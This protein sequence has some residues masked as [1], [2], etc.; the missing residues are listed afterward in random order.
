MLVDS[1]S[2]VVNFFQMS[3]FEMV[4][5]IIHSTTYLKDDSKKSVVRN[6]KNSD[7]GKMHIPKSFRALNLTDFGAL[8]S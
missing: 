1:L 6:D 5:R 7:R 4:E 8:S 3:L 2:V